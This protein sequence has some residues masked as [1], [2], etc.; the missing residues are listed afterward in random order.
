M[1]REHAGTRVVDELLWSLRR[2]GLAISTSQAI[3]V[4]RAVALV[5][6]YEKERLRQTLAAILVTERA[7]ARTF[8]RAFERYFSGSPP[9]RDLFE[10]LLARGL[11][12]EDVRALTEL[13]HAMANASADGA[14]LYALSER[15]AELDRLLTSASV[16]R[17]LEA[18][19]GPLQAGFVTHKVLAEV[20]A[21]RASAGLGAL[22]VRLTDALGKE[23]SDALLR[24][25]SQELLET[26]DQVREHVRDRLAAS[27]MSSPS[28]AMHRAF[29]ALSDD[30][31]ADVR[32]GVRKFVERL[33]GGARVRRRLR[34]RGRIDPHGTLRRAMKT[35]GVPIFPVRRQRREDRAKLLVFADVSDSVRAT[36]RFLLEFAYLA[37]ELFERTRTFAFVSELVETTQLFATESIDR[38]LSRVYGGALLSVRDNSNY[39]RVL[40]AIEARYGPEIDRRTTIVIL[41]DGR[42]NYMETGVGSLARLRS[43]AKNVIWLC[44][45]SRAS[46]SVGDSRMREYARASSQVFEMTNARELERAARAFVCR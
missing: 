10:R 25:L 20:G 39:G 9:S 5:G 29:A 8:E 32:R 23:R 35:H 21:V 44:P 34:K 37:G 27:E 14:S 3:D 11:P 4:V 24:A 13:L 7:D 12:A 42:T 6:F 43:R 41:G 30:E 45:E 38:A 15:G 1:A 18:A 33:W 16:V 17:T 31:V 2:G 40:A 22:G 46:W 36:A 28:D 19:H 26:E